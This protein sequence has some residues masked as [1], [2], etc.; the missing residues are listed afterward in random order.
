MRVSGS[1]GDCYGEGAE[2][3]ALTRFMAVAVLELFFSCGDGPS[4]PGFS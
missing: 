1:G 2:A 3:H 4:V